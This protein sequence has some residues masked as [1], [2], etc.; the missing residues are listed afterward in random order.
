[1]LFCRCDKT[2]HD[3]SSL[4]KKELAYGSRGLEFIAVL[5]A[6][7]Q[8]AAGGWHGC[9]RRKLTAHISITSTKQKERHHK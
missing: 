7:Q 9:R 4:K 2:Q 6:W 1:M 3:Q 5:T 8:V